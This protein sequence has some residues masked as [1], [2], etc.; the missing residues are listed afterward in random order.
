M[1]NCVSTP[2]DPDKIKI[3]LKTTRIGKKIVVYNST[4]STNDAAAKY[5]K[6]KNNDGLV[7]LAEEQVK[8]RGRSGN[9]WLSGKG[10]SVICSILLTNCAINAELLSLTM[11][12]ATA[13]AIGKCVKAE[14]KI[15]WPND[16]IL[17][18]KKVAGILVESKKANK[19]NALIIG[20]G[21]N[22]HQSKT[23]F[24]AELRKTATSID[25]ETGGTIDRTSLIKRL[26]TSIENSLEI[27]EQNKDEII[28][29]WQ[30]LSTQLGQRVTLVYNRKKFAGNCIGIDPENG[31]I[32]QLDTGGIRMFH[33]AQTTMAKS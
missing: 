31:L 15:K 11:A 24:P 27:A 6:S 1:A 14:A 10:D 29:D 12:V 22:C 13:E 8:G 32:L 23:D 5:A 30:R 17:N 33:A 28:E 2:L 9:K 21:I 20:I 7:V 16:I 26:L 4:A 25:I 19:S 18:N 3:N